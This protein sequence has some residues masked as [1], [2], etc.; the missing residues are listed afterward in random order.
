[1]IHFTE[2]KKVKGKRI[3]L[4]DYR[5]FLLLLTITIL[6]LFN[7][8]YIELL[9]TIGIVTIFLLAMH[10]VI[11]R[12]HIIKVNSLWI[13]FGFFCFYSTIMLLRTP[14]FNAIYAFMLQL[15]LL[16]LLCLLSSINLKGI[17]LKHI[18]VFGR[19][20]YLLLLIPACI[21]AIRGNILKFSPYFSPV[22]Y[23][24]MVPCT[25]FFMAN[26]S[27]RLLKIILFSLLFFLMTERISLITL[28]VIYIAYLLLGKLKKSKFLYNAFFCVYFFSIGI[29]NYIYVNLQYTELGYLLNRI[30]REYTGGNLF[31]GRNVIWE[32]AF[33]YIL[34]SPIWGYGIDNR[35]L[36]LSGINLS[37]HNTYIHLLLQGG[38]V[39][40]LIFFMFMYSIWKIYFDSLDDDIVRT[41]AAYLIGVLF[42]INF[43]VTMIGNTVNI[44]LFLWVILGI[45]LIQR[46]NNKQVFKL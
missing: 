43:E 19:I 15:I 7:N 28:I 10:D 24:L 20:I 9:G 30:F 13:W 3:F 21:V 29:F 22:I 8:L 38:F 26:S 36:Y 46:N 12:S 25:F 16:F 23:K 35:L 34:E 45:G 6:Y 2:K 11:L 37:T 17:A 18:F 33:N 41:S 27:H 1:M 44:A 32:V 39:G 4:I 40:L 42:F 31:S 5:V 14:S